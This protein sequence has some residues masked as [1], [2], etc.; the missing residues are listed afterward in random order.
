MCKFF[1]GSYKRLPTAY[2]QA[3][4]RQFAYLHCNLATSSSILTSMQESLTS[5]SVPL[6]AISTCYALGVLDSSWSLLLVQE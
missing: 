5:F 6:F 2:S 3:L 1:P 4:V